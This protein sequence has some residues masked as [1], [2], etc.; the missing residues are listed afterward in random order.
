MSMPD[1]KTRLVVAYVDAEGK[2]QPITP[3]SSFSPT[4]ALAAEVMHSIEATHIGVI[5]Q[6]QNISFTMT[7]TAI[8]DAAARLTQFA[9]EGKLFDIDLQEETGSDWSFKSV[10]LSR[11]LVTS[12]QPSA[13]VISGAPSATFSGVCLGATVDGKPAGSKVTLPA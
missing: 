5:Y 6:P 3:I 12:A 9:L 2:R 11:C 8:G 13:A 10:V 4:F 1:W 7:V